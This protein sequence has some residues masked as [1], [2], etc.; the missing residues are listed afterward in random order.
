M[1][2]EKSSVWQSQCGLASVV[3]LL[4]L[5]YDCKEAIEYRHVLMQIYQN[6]Q[7]WNETLHAQQDCLLVVLTLST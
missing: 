6:L 2:L 4:H 5:A 7:H 1:C 3:H